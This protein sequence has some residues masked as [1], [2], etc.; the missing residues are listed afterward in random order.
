M[1]S[2]TDKDKTLMGRKTLSEVQHK[3]DVVKKNKESLEARLH[4]YEQKLENEKPRM[5]NA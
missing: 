4:F 2:P 1:L 3:I 5:T